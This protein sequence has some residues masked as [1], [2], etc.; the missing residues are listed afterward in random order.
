[1]PWEGI[2]CWSPVFPAKTSDV[3]LAAATATEIITHF[4]RKGE[5]PNKNFMYKKEYDEDGF[6]IGYRQINHEI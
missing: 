4:L 1:M 5:T 3:M 6:L 2:G